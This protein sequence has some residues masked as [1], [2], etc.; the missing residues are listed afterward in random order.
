MHQSQ[1][2]YFRF[3]RGWYH[4]AGIDIALVVTI[5]RTVNDHQ[6]GRIV[7]FA[8]E[9]CD[10]VSFVSFQPASFTGRD[11]DSDDVT[12]AERRYTLSHLAED[13]KKQTGATDPLRDWFP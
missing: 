9:N 4:R 8:G 5:V 12:R 10:K 7:K 1:D 3:I 13:V 2:L 6:V 11:E